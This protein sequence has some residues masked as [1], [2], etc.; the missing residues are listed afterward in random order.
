MV[1]SEF[2]PNCGG[3]GYHVFYLSKE[4]LKMGWD[5]SVVFR[6]RENRRYSYEGIDAT[7]VQVPGYPPLNLP[8]FRRRLNAIIS[9]ERPDLVHI[10]YGAVPAIS[11]DCPV[12]VTAHWCNR[13]GIPIYYRPVRDL[14][15]FL[16]NLLSPYY[17]HIERKLSRSTDKLLVVSSSLRDEFE[18]HY[19]VRGDVVLNGIDTEA[20]NSNGTDKEDVILFTGMF[21]LGKGLFDLLAVEGRLRQSHPGV[22]V[23]MVGDGP[24]KKKVQAAIRRDGL[25]NVETIGHLTHPELLE[26]YRRSRIYVLPSYYEG[27]PTTILEA[28][29]CRLPVVASNV[30]GIPEQ[31]D[32]GVTGYMLPPGDVDGFYNRIVELLEDPVKQ[33]SFGEMGRKRVLEKFAWSHIAEGITGKY[34]E[35]LQAGKENA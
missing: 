31:I 30:S 17:I 2:P 8:F 28:M 25:D 14:D 13:E 21:R 6:G 10:H 15:G 20:F 33:K 11:C 9:G 3:I 7:E 29:A 26:H 34:L 27:L 23:V 18:R 12:I 5:V 32:E 35:L 4:L 24:M 22:R 1:A 16:R 19:D